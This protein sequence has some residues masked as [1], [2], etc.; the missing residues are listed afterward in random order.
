MLANEVSSRLTPYTL[1]LNTRLIAFRTMV[2]FGDKERYIGEAANSQY[3]RNLK[4]TITD[5]KRLLGHSWSEKEIQEEIADLPFTVKELPNHDVGVE[6]MY[7]GEKR[8][9]S[10][11]SI[12]A[13]LLQKLK[14][15]AEKALGRAVRDVVIS[16]PAFWTDKQ[17]RAL[18]DATKIANLNCLRLMNDHAAGEIS[19]F[20][21][22]YHVVALNYGI[23]KTNLSETDPIRV[24]FYDMGHTS[25]TVSIVEFV[26]GKLKVL[27]SAHDRTMGGRNFD[28]LLLQHF[29]KEFKVIA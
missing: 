15:T 2:A 14:E 13:M 3:M 6:V 4:N 9:F 17:R 8:T 1:Q 18:L 10:I 23:Y 25:T 16:V 24:M 7:A 19:H 5:I 26:K 12:A 29:A 20:A 21:S 28:K 22:T 27:S 11:I